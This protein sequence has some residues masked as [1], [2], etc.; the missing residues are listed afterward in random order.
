MSLSNVVV[1]FIHLASLRA[2]PFVMVL[3]QWPLFQMFVITPYRRLIL[4]FHYHVLFYRCASSKRIKKKKKRRVLSRPLV[5]Y[6]NP[7]QMGWE[8]GDVKLQPCINLQTNHIKIEVKLFY[9]TLPCFDNKQLIIITM[10]MIYT[11]TWMSRKHELFS[12][13]ID[14]FYLLNKRC[15]CFK[16]S[17]EKKCQNSSNQIPENKNNNKILRSSFFRDSNVQYQQLTG[18]K[19]TTHTHTKS[20]FCLVK[21]EEN[22]RILKIPRIYQNKQFF[23]FFFLHQK[24]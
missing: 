10:M 3:Y 20:Q 24:E 19:K 7:N 9:W 14:L 6:K 12:S 2:V 21:S 13:K 5:G 18:K 22:F 17:T 11:G 1:H 15:W 16:K 23:F 8:M 4:V